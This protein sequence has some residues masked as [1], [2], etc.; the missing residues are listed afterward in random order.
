MDSVERGEIVEH[1]EG[2]V[3][4]TPELGGLWG[5]G[6]VA[7]DR[8]AEDCRLLEVRTV[9]SDV[10]LERRFAHVDLPLERHVP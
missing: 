4:D 8:E 7:G 6:L 2:Q 9:Q 3:D 5:G 1:R 10:T